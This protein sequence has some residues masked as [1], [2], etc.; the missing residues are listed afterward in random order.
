MTKGVVQ[1]RGGYYFIPGLFY[2]PT[3]IL[4]LIGFGLSMIA[5]GMVKSRFNKYSKVRSMA[6]MTGAQVAQRVLQAAGI[7]DV[8]IEEVAGNLTDHYDPRNKVLRLSQSVYNSVSIAAV[9][10]AAHECGHAIQHNQNY[11]PLTFRSTFVPVA[12]L[13]S[14]MAWPIFFLGL[15]VGRPFLLK[16]GIILFAAAVIFQLV[17]VPVEINASRRALKMIEQTGILYDEEAKGAKSVLTAAA[18]T[19]VAAL[20]ASILQLLRLILLAG[21]GRRRD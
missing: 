2:D 3:F 5:S 7:N 12:N 14:S 21:G 8:S 4:I 18:L 1:L 10:V 20:A 17:T 19:Y 11:A 6:G 15:I 9:G 13:G 16:A